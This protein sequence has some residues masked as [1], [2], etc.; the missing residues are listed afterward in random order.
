[1]KKV[2]KNLNSYLLFLIPAFLA[3][4]CFTVFSLTLYL[5]Y[6]YK[7]ILAE[8]EELTVP[9]YPKLMDSLPP[10]EISAK[11]A[12]VLD[13]DSRVVIFSKNPN[14]VFSPAST[15]KLMTA[16]V[17]LDYFSPEAVLKVKRAPFLDPDIVD[18]QEGDKFRF[19]DLLY[20]MLLPSS[21]QAAYI[22][23]YNYPGGIERF[24]WQMNKK[25]KELDLLNTRFEDPAG[26]KDQGSF[27]NVSDLARLGIAA[28]DNKELKKIVRTREKFIE[29]ADSTAV[30]FIQNL[31]ELLGEPGID[32]IK[33]GY[34][35]ESGQ[36]LI[37]S[38]NIVSQTGEPKTLI[39]VVMKSEDRFEDSRKLLDYVSRDVSFVSI[40]SRRQEHMR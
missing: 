19:E 8:E 26:L 20:A 5:E 34:T 1:M 38:K 33:T 28:Y 16:L 9:S 18:F 3:V 11:S 2:K 29:N 13:K 22:I 31:N 4:F 10:P 25:A 40:P 23:A 30:Y 39:S 27:S 24:V 7:P 14:L 15:T 37:V 6:I 17:G 35:E 32:G 21:N 12:I 36:V